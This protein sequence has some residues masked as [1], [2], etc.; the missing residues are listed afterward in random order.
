MYANAVV[1]TFS[2]ESTD[3]TQKAKNFFFFG[4]IHDTI[5]ISRTRDSA[6]SC[7]WYLQFARSFAGRR[8]ITESL[9][10]GY[11]KYI[12]RKVTHD[13]R[14]TWHKTKNGLKLIAMTQFNCY[15]F[16][17][18]SLTL[19]SRFKRF[20]FAQPAIHLQFSACRFSV[21]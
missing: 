2:T 16:F 18:L 14:C 6:A 1:V 4:I 8:I 20:I 21:N 13:A 11:L 3:Q 17:R 5:Q 7:H 12:T 19:R 9:L 10:K 15:L